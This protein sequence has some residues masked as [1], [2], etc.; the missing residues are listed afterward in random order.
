VGAPGGPGIIAVFDA[1]DSDEFPPLVVTN[2]VNVYGTLPDNP[3]ITVVFILERA[4]APVNSV[5]VL[6]PVL[7]E[8]DTIV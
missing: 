5:F 2:T 6:I 4:I 3:V 1:G 8:V 7:P